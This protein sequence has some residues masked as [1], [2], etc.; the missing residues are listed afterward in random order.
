MIKKEHVAAA[1]IKPGMH[2]KAPAKR[3]PMSKARA[4]TLESMKSTE[5]EAARGKKRK[6]WVKNTMARVIGKP[7][8]MEESDEEEDAEDAAPAPKT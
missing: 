6:E 5:E 8:M 7:S 1:R 4:S 3:V 2:K